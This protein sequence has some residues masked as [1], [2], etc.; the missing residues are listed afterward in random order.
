MAYYASNFF[1]DFGFNGG[2]GFG[3]N[4]PGAAFF[5]DNG[6]LREYWLN[7]CLDMPLQAAGSTPPQAFILRHVL[8]CN[9]PETYRFLR[10]FASAVSEE[11]QTECGSWPIVILYPI[12][13]RLVGGYESFRATPT[14]Y[15]SFG[16]P[17]K[18]RIVI[19][20]W[21]GNWDVVMD[22]ILAKL[23]LNHTGMIVRIEEYVFPGE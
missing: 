3:Y 16:P 19:R 22:S 13:D 21:A 5:G 23:T 17:L 15:E 1:G 14:G 12:G 7:H 18:V 4:G 2:G 20:D 9:V 10:N 6:N 8:P 11:Y